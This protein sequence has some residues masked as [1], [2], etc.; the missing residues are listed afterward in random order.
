MLQSCQVLRECPYYLLLGLTMILGSNLLINFIALQVDVGSRYVFNWLVLSLVQWVVLDQL[1]TTINQKGFQWLILVAPLSFSTQFL[2]LFFVH[3]F[4][5]VMLFS[6]LFSWVEFSY[7]GHGFVHIFS[8]CMIAQVIWCMLSMVI[9]V[10]I[11]FETKSNW[12]ALMMGVL[13]AFPLHLMA[14]GGFL[15]VDIQGSI[16]MSLELLFGSMWILLVFFIPLLRWGFKQS[17]DV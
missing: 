3:V 1:I 15:M 12:I 2:V 5:Y 4:T 9:R 10:L 6:L 13:L 8:I 7:M 17:L 11:G 14:L 16:K